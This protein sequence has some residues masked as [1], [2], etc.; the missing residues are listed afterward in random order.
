M[1]WGIIP[2]VF[3]EMKDHGDTV[4]SYPSPPSVATKISYI[5]GTSFHQHFVSHFVFYFFIY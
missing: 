2:A 3:W 1:W 5:L 4:G